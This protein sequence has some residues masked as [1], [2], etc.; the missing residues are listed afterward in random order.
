M[1]KNYQ[2]QY[3]MSRITA[4]EIMR[5]QM[6]NYRVGD[7][8]KRGEILDLLESVL[9]RPRKSLIRSMNGLLN[10]QDRKKKR[11]GKNPHTYKQAANRVLPRGPGRPKKYLAETDA[12]LHYIWKAYNCPCA[13]R[14]HP[15]IKEA[16]RIFARDEEWDYSIEATEQ[17]QNMTLSSMRLRLVNFAHKDGLMRGFSTTRS[18]ELLNAITIFH[19]DWSKKPLGYGQID[20]VVHSG[21]KLQGT[22]AYTVNFVEM[23]TYW[24][25]LKAQLGKDAGT[26]VDS[27]KK[28]ERELPFR[29]RGLHP[30][31]GDEFINQTLIS[32]VKK[33]NSRRVPEHQIELTRSRPSKKNDNCN[34]EERNN[35][36]VR[37]YIG[38]ER[39][40]CTEAVLILNELYRNLCLYNNFFQPTYKLV[41]KYRKANGQYVRKYDEPRSP[42]RRLL[43]RDEIPNETKMELLK[44]Y[45]GLNPRKLLVRI[46]TLTTKLRKVQQELGYHFFDDGIEPHHNQNGS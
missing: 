3:A 24:V 1:G 44:Q 42:F 29:L 27:I 39:Y 43:E 36:L 21:P 9:H 15:E 46:R 20:T 28:I 8:N 37:K 17:L 18:S 16:I 31:S 26:T 22:M 30:D 4:K 10:Y 32:W 2:L 13:E 14:L 40:D 41:S 5:E 35:E 23:Q 11:S 19:G 6:H 7:K 38:Y 12:A 25:E 33:K 45:N 34:V